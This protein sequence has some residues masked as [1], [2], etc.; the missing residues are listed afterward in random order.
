M[1]ILLINPKVPES[2]WSFKWAVD[3]ILSSDKRVINPPLGLATVAALCPKDWEVEIIDENIESIPLEPQADIIGVCGMGVQFKRQ[4]EL[5][6]FYKKKG[7]FVVAGG[8]YASLCPEVYESFTDTVVAGEAEY[9]WGKFCIDFELGKPQKLYKET[10]TVDLKDSPV[11]RFDLLKLESYQRV[12]LQFS[13]GCPYRCEFCDIIVMFGRK[14]RTKSLEQIGSELDV[15]RKLHADNVFFVDDNLIGKKRVAKELLRF[16]SDYQLK[17]KY[18]FQ[19]GTEASLDMADDEELL[20]LLH[21]ANFE[22]VFIGIESPD[23]ESLKETKKLQNTRQDILSSVRKIYSHGIEILAGF[24][25]GFDNDTMKTFDKQFR[26]I[27]DS[28]IQTA[29]IG[30]LTALPKT[31]LYER[32]GKEGRLIAD[33]D[34]ADNTVLGTNF[35]PKQ[36]GYEE[37]VKGYRSLYNQLLK[38]RNIAFRIKNKIRYLRNPVHKIQQYPLREVLP[39]IKNFFFRGIKPGGFSRVFY[40]CRSLPVFRPKLIPIVIHDWVVGLAMRDYVERQFVQEFEKVNILAKSYLGLIKKTFQGYLDHGALEVNLSQMKNAASNLSI[41]M[42]GWLDKDFF[43]RIDKHLQKVLKHTTSSITFRIEEFH[44]AQQKHFNRLLKKL[45][46][47][48]DRIHIILNEK[49]RNMVEVDS[50]IF[51]LVLEF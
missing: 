43:T 25:I 8:S 51:N 18:K 29:M 39:I 3:K 9:I 19:F 45:S 47:H 10:G 48:G 34:S 23:A 17:Y 30:L 28:G 36:M 16:L 27:M 26:F 21:Q 38:D 22:W 49:V 20:E 13:R 7:F 31:P 2:F 24:I 44:E 42:K 32:L 40:F 6:T 37:M 1:K 12:S 4:K 33:A 15:L 5:L 46:R 14:P 35:L 50:S 41:S 11:P